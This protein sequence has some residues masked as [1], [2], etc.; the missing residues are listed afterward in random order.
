[1]KNFLVGSR[2]ECLMTFSSK[3]F[4]N[5]LN[6]H[7]VWRIMWM[8]LR[9]K[10]IAVCK[11]PSCLM[12]VHGRN[13][14]MPLSHSLPVFYL[15]HPYYDRLP[16]RISAYIHKTQRKVVCV[17]VGANIGDTVAA[18]MRDEKDRF[19]A[20][21][22]NPK[23]LKHLKK[24]WGSTPNV[25]I[26]TDVCSSQ[27]SAAHFSI[28][29]A[30]GTATITESG[31][32]KV[33]GC[34][35]LDDIVEEHLNNQCVNVVKIDTDGYDFEVLLGGKATIAKSRPI[36][37]FEC[38]LFANKQFVS[39]VIATLKFF[40]SCG[41][42]DFLIYDNCGNLM[43]RFSLDD[44]SIVY[45]LLFYKLQGGVGYYDILLLPS[46]DSDAFYRAEVEWFLNENHD[47][48]GNINMQEICNYWLLQSKHDAC[49]ECN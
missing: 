39:D 12:Q 1:M 16:G 34:R 28:L 17:D 3:V 35:T 5:S 46:Q 13:L 23:F 31:K 7:G 29:E 11:D 25:E 32:V 41:Y 38:D 4:N 33:S 14:W 2:E 37:L 45:Q 20:V 27:K 24:N 47:S 22:P 49:K 26:V 21:E 10:I 40:K 9:R 48:F 30:N 8:Y 18:F 15:E 36:V 42:I 44:F 6:S 19:I 43:G